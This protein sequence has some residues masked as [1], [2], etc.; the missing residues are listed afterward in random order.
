MN[1]MFHASPPPDLSLKVVAAV[2]IICETDEPEA[3]VLDQHA[4][5]GI[6]I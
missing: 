3:V 2:A 5:I 4:N 6:T 1:R